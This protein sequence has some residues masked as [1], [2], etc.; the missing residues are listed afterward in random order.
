MLHFFRKFFNIASL[1]HAMIN[2]SYT[3]HANIC[4]PQVAGRRREFIKPCCRNEVGK[5]IIDKVQKHQWIST[6]GMPLFLQCEHR[7]HCYLGKS[8]G[9]FIFYLY[10]IP[11]LSCEFQ[12][13]SV[14]GSMGHQQTGGQCFVET[15][16]SFHMSIIPLCK[17]CGHECTV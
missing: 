9:T 13:R 12:S 14:A 15:H 16:S 8:C 11:D 2:C 7:A 4:L 6:H 17:H 5:K 10:M 1:C 3:G